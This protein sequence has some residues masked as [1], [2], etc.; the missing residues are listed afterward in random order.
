MFKRFSMVFSPLAESVPQVNRELLEERERE[1]WAVE[2][3]TQ[4]CASTDYAAFSRNALPRV[5][6][7]KR[8]SAIGY[9]KWTSSDIEDALRTP[10]PQGVAATARAII[11]PILASAIFL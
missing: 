3:P 7:N 6:W 11:S 4:A 5:A 2:I 9:G 8:R 1:A 10:T